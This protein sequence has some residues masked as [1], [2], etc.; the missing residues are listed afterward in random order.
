M[1]K[2]SMR[3]VDQASFNNTF[4]KAL[5]LI[6]KQKNITRDFHFPGIAIDLR[7]GMKI[8]VDLG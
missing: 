7:D 4:I 6:Q 2:S 8:S 5:K 3:M 1:P